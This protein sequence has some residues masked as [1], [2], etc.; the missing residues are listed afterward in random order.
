MVQRRGGGDCARVYEWIAKYYLRLLNGQKGSR[1]RICSSFPR[2]YKFEG[3]KGAKRKKNEKVKEYGTVRLGRMSSFYIL[4][5]SLILLKP[6]VSSYGNTG[7]YGGG[8]FLLPFRISRNG[9]CRRLPP[10]PI[11]IT[12]NLY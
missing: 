6:F 8:F 4:F 11:N 5:F 3:N 9:S 10:R 2:D 1:R 7:Q 12:D